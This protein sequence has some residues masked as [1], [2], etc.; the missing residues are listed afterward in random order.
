MTG[1]HPNIKRQDL[2]LDYNKGGEQTKMDKDKTMKLADF[3]T[4]DSIS[5]A[6]IDG[7]KFTIVAVEQSN[8]D[9]TPGVKI[10]TLE[11]FTVDGNLDPVNRFHT[12]RT[13]IFNKLMSEKIQSALKAGAK[14]GPV[15]AVLAQ[16]KTPGKKDYFVLEDA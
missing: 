9:D 14:I 1:T 5:L 15:T 13:A 8:Y 2:L 10:T 7:Q 11:S 12:T 16:N 4:S 3:P 6:K